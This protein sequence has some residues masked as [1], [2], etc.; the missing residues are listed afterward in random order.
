[1]R[2]S[3]SAEEIAFYRESGFLVVEGFLDAAELDE[4]R[5][6]T[7]EACELRVG[8]SVPKQGEHLLHNQTDAGNY[9]A[10]AFKQCLRLADIH[11]GMRK[12]ILDPRLGRIGA[13]LAGVDGL[14]VWHDQALIKPPYGNPTAWHLDN[15]YWSFTSRDAL[16]IWVALEDATPQNGCLYYIPGSHKT[17]QHDKNC[18]IGNVIS[19]L[20]QLY[21]EWLD[22][23][24]AQ[25][26]CRA[27]SAVWHNG[28]T[29]HGAGANMTPAP[30]PAMTCGFMPDGCTFNGQQNILSGEYMATLQ[31]GDALDDDVQNPLVWHR[32]WAS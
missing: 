31:I 23:A 7:Y 16:S 11:D 18:G 9:Y 3:V 14:R 28:M 26:A 5:R 30:R 2:D 19:E 29:A 22:I 24:P 20:F 32:S 6:C 25:A 10:Q 21:P 17:A 1:M 27:G 8:R 13:T 12:L 15:P 4:W